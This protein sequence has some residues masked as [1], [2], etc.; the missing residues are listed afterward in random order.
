MTMALSAIAERY[1]SRVGE[2][3]GLLRFDGIAT[4]RGDNNRLLG[5]FTCDCGNQVSLHA[6]RTLNG[7]KRS[8]CGCQ[9]DRGTHR[10]HGMRNSREYSSWMS[11]KARC[12]Y[13]NNKDYPRWGGCG[14]TICPEWVASFEAFYSHI[15]ERPPGTTLDRINTTRDYEP[16]NVRWA[17]HQEQQR[18]RRTSYRWYIKGLEFETHGEAALH[19]GVSEHTVWRWVN[20]Q[21]DSR[22]GTFT[23][24]LEN[25]YVIARY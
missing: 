24:P 6:G 14:I 18:N 19:F 13:P 1:G 17:T 22:R 7:K 25:C 3:V 4:S 16:G 8:H 15:G 10:T 21:F 23:K 11:M 20:G 9:T 12:L 5:L 2:R